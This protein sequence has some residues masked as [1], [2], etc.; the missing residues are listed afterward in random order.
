M[1]KI[2]V[3]SDLALARK[4]GAA[5]I[6]TSL[7]NMPFWAIYPVLIFILYK[8]LHATPLQI[9]IA[10]MSKPLVSIFSVYWSSHVNQ[11]R[12]RLLANVKW[13]AVIGPIPFLLFPFIDNA[14]YVIFASGFYITM[15]R[16]VIPAWME[17]LKLNLPDLY[18]KQVVSRSFAFSFVGS[19]ILSILVGW[20][21]DDHFQ[22][23]RWIF[24]LTALISM[25]GIFFQC[26]IHV[27]LE[28][29]S[30]SRQQNIEKKSLKIRLIQPW[31]DGWA[32]I[33]ARSD[34]SQYLLGMMLGGFGLVIIQPALPV[35]FIDGLNLSYAELTTA[36]TLCK[37]FSFALT[38]PFWSRLLHKRNIYSFCCLVSLLA[39]CFPL[40]LI[41]AQMNVLLIYVAYLVYGIM[42]GGS[43]L[44]WHLSGPI[45]SKNEDS[46]SYSSVNLGLVGLRG[47]IAPLL[48][49]LLVESFGAIS[50]L[51]IGCTLSLAAAWRMYVYSR[52]DVPAFNRV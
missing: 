35:F 25:M 27:K 32:L 52:Q 33:Q 37:G 34:F 14:W 19:G 20:L 36:L 31:T 46:S 40:I 24:P 12:D 18:C 10:L 3:T 49:S 7:L 44:S 4:T 15:A 9:T 45:F 47:C 16:G 5:F 29:D 11:R 50:V 51:L 28:N 41:S 2:E 13:A 22:I 38:S 48:G 1:N 42:Q 17:I 21:M 39:A 26:Q 30:L 8:D 6:W 23:W 43:E